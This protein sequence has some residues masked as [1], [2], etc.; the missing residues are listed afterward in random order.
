MN[1]PKAKIFTKIVKSTSIFCLEKI[2]IIK[3]N[4]DFYL[5]FIHFVSFRL[6]NITLLLL[7]HTLM[8]VN[9]EAEAQNRRSFNL[10]VRLTYHDSVY[11]E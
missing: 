1:T 10:K 6:N 4:L 7:I 8:C 9:P 11:N 5:Y 2:I 3:S